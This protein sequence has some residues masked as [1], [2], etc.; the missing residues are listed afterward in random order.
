MNLSKLNYSTYTDLSNYRYRLDGSNVDMAV[1]QAELASE[2]IR[3]QALTRAMTSEF[4]RL[5]TAMTTS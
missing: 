4:T 3:Y 1:E 2:Q 5:R